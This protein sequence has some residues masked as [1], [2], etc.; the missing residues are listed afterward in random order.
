[1]RVGELLVDPAR[2]KVVVGEREVQLTEEFGLLRI[3]AS[4]PT[5]VFA[6][7]ELLAEVWG[8]RRPPGPT[9]T[10]DSHVSRLRRKLDPDHDRYVVNCWRIGY[11][12]VDA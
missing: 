3:L 4:D 6:K 2:W 10:V 12:L 5:R 7:D 1:M 11:R 8:S 9:R